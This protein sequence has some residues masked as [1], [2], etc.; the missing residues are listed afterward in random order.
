[1]DHLARDRVLM[2]GRHDG[3]LTVEAIDR[4]DVRPTF[5]LR[6]ERPITFLVTD[7]PVRYIPARVA[8]VQ[9]AGLRGLLK[10]PVVVSSWSR[11]GTS[12]RWFLRGEM[13]ATTRF[14]CCENGA[15]PPADKA[16]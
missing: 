3:S 4:G 2:A 6:T 16:E 7:D 13:T 5:R 9:T 10:P 11:A 1:M 12:A 8:L 15:T 14:T